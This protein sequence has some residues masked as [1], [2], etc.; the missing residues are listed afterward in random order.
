M[1]VTL[2]PLLVNPTYGEALSHPTY[3]PTPRRFSRVGGIHPSIQR[4]RFFG[5]FV[6][7]KEM[8]KEALFCLGAP[9]GVGCG[10]AW[11]IFASR[12]RQEFP[13]F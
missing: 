1:S 2:P 11:G 7:G 12:K 6:R 3:P 10:R 5:L 8:G 13:L 9:R 4:L